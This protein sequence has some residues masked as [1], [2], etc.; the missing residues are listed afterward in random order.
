MDGNSLPSKEP[1][2]LDGNSNNFC[3]LNTVRNERA[4]DEENSEDVIS[5]SPEECGHVNVPSDKDFSSEMTSE[6]E[7]VR[8]DSKNESE[9]EMLKGDSETTQV[10]NAFQDC[11]AYTDANGALV[12]RITQKYSDSP[13]ENSNN[14]FVSP[15]NVDGE[16]DDEYSGN[17][18]ILLNAN[19]D[20]NNVNPL[21]TEM[22]N[23]STAEF[24][25]NNNNERCQTES[26]SANK[27]NSLSLSN[28]CGKGN[29]SE[30]DRVNG[31]DR[32]LLIDRKRND[33]VEAFVDHSNAEAETSAKDEAGATKEDAGDFDEALEF[34]VDHFAENSDDER[35]EGP[36]EQVLVSELSDVGRYSYACLMAH[37]LH[38]LFGYSS[39]NRLGFFQGTSL[40]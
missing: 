30:D 27:T 3:Q 21:N 9:L 7:L 14:N 35:K 23:A 33:T 6:Q 5:V 29:A 38:T 26:L 13:V 40:Y 22:K 24:S 4:N 36:E 17:A 15:T 20:S 1:N 8:R 16:Q 2:N 31:N 11:D 28:S 39:S 25:I 34:V 32:D 10:D 37:S 18:N 19:C 12:K